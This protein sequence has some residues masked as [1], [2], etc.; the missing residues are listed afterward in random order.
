[1][2]G[3]SAFACSGRC[4]PSKKRR[5]LAHPAIHIL[6]LLASAPKH[7]SENSPAICSSADRIPRGSAC[8]RERRRGRH[9][10]MTIF[11]TASR[12][13]VLPPPAQILD[14]I[15]RR[16]HSMRSQHVAKGGQLV[17]HDE[18]EQRADDRQG[19]HCGRGKSRRCD[20][21][22]G[23]ASSQS[24]PCEILVPARRAT[25]TKEAHSGFNASPSWT[26]TLVLL[27]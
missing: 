15:S 14:D 21:E 9:L 23:C 6:F 17:V 7:R 8:R 18:Q 3:S 5:K 4:A 25:S 27:F 19:K 26:T 24:H 1:M 11:R 20:C 22:S 2:G 16:G 12:A 13:T 10:A